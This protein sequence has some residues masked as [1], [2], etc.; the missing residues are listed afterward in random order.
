M[1]VAFTPD[2]KTIISG[3]LNGVINIWKIDGTKL[4][5]VKTDKEFTSIT[6]GTDGKTI[7]AGGFYDISRGFISLISI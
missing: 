5:T 4:A 2:N 6:L 7:I 1:F 3:T